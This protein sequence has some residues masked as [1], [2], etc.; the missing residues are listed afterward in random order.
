MLTK[1]D[2]ILFLESPLHLW[3]LKHDALTISSPSAYDQHLMQQG[4]QVE[5]IAHQLLPM[6]EWQKTFTYNEYEARVDALVKNP[7]GG[8]DIYEIKSTTKVEKEHIFDATFQYLVAKNT[9]QINKIYV[10]T[11][12]K[13]YILNGE[14]NTFE[15]F[16]INDITDKVKDNEN[17]IQSQMNDA[18]MVCKKDSPI[19]ITNC[20]N[21]KTCPCLNLCYP[22]LPEVSIF[23]IPN[24]S[25]IKKR[26][27]VDS[28][29]LDINSIPT[30]F[31]LSAKQKRILNILKTNI[32]YLNTIA[33]RNFLA[34]LDF[35]LFFLDYET[36]PSAIPIY[37]G[38]KPYQQMVFQY[39]LH[40]VE[41]D[42]D[43][44]HFEYLE[45]EKGDPSAKLL[46]KLQSDLGDVGSVIVWNKVFEYERNKDMAETY[47]EYAS[48]LNQVNSRMIDLAD[49]INKEYYIGPKFSGSWS[50]KNVLPVMVPDLSYKDLKVNKGDIAMLTWW[51]IINSTDK[52]KA[53]DLLDYCA[54]DTLA[55]V[56]IWEKLKQITA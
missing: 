6:A 55:M 10:V 2:F 42:G 18:L 12:N 50:I 31:S 8:Y 34:D 4:Y 11:L 33:L 35:P 25:P 14:L 21:P 9:I 43:I 37:E 22:Q 53:K 47:K 39:S 13:D 52:S 45:T 23:N 54:M 38:Y 1:T 15:L 44:Y 48:F 41:K 5:K 3:A 28:K 32:D 24:L 16:S 7:D 19:Y 17:E 36:Y 49:F 40:K 29:I 26:E 27:L 46:V 20:L 30:S 51:E 56:K